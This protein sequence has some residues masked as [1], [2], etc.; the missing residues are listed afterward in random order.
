[1]GKPCF[2]CLCGWIGCDTSA[3]PASEYRN[4]CLFFK[5][6]K[7]CL[8]GDDPRGCIISAGE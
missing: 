4:K 5:Q 6:T 2:S 3:F 8:I 1:M 7:R